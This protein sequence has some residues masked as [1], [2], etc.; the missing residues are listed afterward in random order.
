MVSKAFPLRKYHKPRL[1]SAVELGSVLY[2]RLVLYKINPSKPALSPF[3]KLSTIVCTSANKLSTTTSRDSSRLLREAVNGLRMLSVVAV[4]L[5]CQPRFA[6]TTS[7]K[8][9]GE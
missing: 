3:N 2:Q 8:G 6:A 1:V 7:P 9:Q 4:F 5:V